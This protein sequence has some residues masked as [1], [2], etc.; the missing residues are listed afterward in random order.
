[1]PAADANPAGHW[2]NMHIYDAN[3]QILDR[4]GGSWFDPPAVS[5]QLVAQQWGAAT[6]RI[7]V[8][9]LVDQ[10]DG[11]PVAIKDPRIGVMTPLWHSVIADLLHPVLV[12]RDP[13][14]IARSLERR[15]GTPPTFALASWELHMG[16]LIDYLNGR[17]VTVAPYARLL[18]DH[19]VGELVVEQA[20]AHLVAG[21]ATCVRLADAARALERE[22]RHHSV[23]PGEHDEQLTGRQLGLWRWLA[24]LSPGDR[25]IDAP[26]ELR[27]PSVAAR[28]G[29]RNE[30]ARA[31][32]V[33]DL[34]AERGC[35][36]DLETKLVSAREQA[37]SLAARLAIEEQRTSSTAA[38]LVV[39]QRRSAALLAEVASERERVDVVTAAHL[40]AEGWLAAIQ[41]SASW[42][43]TAPLRAAKRLSVAALHRERSEP[44]RLRRPALRHPIRSRF[45][46]GEAEGD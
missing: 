21:R 22:F 27:A 5:A 41:G 26:A 2:E 34:A 4:L 46:R 31:Q 33:R 23:A 43:L 16:G 42:R 39:E 1:M 3:E 40:Q 35:R 10:S 19:R 28:R 29:A 44:R 45:H 37:T 12:V 24:S 36:V 11:A 13:I 25:L 15:D 6:L 8:E 18:E 38:T 17:V 20:A 32:L 14:E 30:T 7:E 9:R